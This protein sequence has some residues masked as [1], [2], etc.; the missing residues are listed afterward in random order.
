MKLQSQKMVLKSR[1][2][3]PSILL[4][5]IMINTLKGTYRTSHLV[6][7]PIVMA[8]DRLRS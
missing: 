4:E 6:V 7:D 3:I 8:L 5:L 1:N 2:V